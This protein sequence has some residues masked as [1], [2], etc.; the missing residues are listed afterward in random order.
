MITVKKELTI[1]L[2]NA[3]KLLMNNVEVFMSN[4]TQIAQDLTE[5]LQ[6]EDERTKARVYCKVITYLTNE[7]CTEIQNINSTATTRIQEELNL[8]DNIDNI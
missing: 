3:D 4:L 7:V 2:K 6:I 1:G 8:G 5:L